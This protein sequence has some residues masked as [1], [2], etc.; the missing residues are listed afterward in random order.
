MQD[1]AK[2]VERQLRNMGPDA[3]ARYQRHSQ[4][5]TLAGTM[6]LTRRGALT[7]N[8]LGNFVTG[9]EPYLPYVMWRPANGEEVKIEEDPELVDQFPSDALLLRL[10]L[11]LK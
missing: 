8:T 10:T 5:E 11:L 3:F 1:V 6:A 9:D 2:Y 4:L 7:W